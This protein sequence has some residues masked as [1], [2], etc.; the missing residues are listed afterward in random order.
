MA[1]DKNS[2]TFVVYVL[3]LKVLES[4]KMTLYLFQLVQVL[5]EV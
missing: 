2:K 5:L 1:L 3:A 4:D